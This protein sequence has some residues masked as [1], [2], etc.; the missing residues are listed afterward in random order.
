M[1]ESITIITQGVLVIRAIQV[2]I[3]NS[4]HWETNFSDFCYQAVYL[5]DFMPPSEKNKL[6]STTQRLFHHLTRRLLGVCYVCDG[7]DLFVFL[8]IKSFSHHDMYPPPNG[9]VFSPAGVAF[10]SFCYVASTSGQTIYAWTFCLMMSLRVMASAANLEIPSR[11][12]STAICSSLKSKRKR[13][14]LLM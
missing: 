1:K 6:T 8:L 11:S 10:C 2:H 5:I 12:F 4:G 9:K 7:V 3:L 14:S 13:G